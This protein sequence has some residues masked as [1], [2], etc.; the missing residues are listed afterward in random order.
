LLLFRSAWLIEG[1]SPDNPIFRCDIE[2]PGQND[3]DRESDHE[4]DQ[5]SLHD[6][7]GRFES[8]EHNFGD[9]DEQPAAKTVR[10]GDLQHAAAPYF[11]E[12]S[13]EFLRTVADVVLLRE[14]V[15]GISRSLLPSARYHVFIAF[16]C[17]EEPVA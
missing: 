15:G 2:D 13:C 11:P 16:P 1:A 4:Y 14:R 8:I 6:P 5:Y 3:S 7:G 9:L 12:K 17:A 10:N